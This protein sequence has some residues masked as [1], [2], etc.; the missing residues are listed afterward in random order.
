MRKLK[1]GIYER[2]KKE[3]Q[4]IAPAIVASKVLKKKLRHNNTRQFYSETPNANPDEDY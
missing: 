3:E 2:V 1:L 4:R